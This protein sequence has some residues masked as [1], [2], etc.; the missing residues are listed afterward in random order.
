MAA[1]LLSWPLFLVFLM[2][3]KKMDQVGAIAGFMCLSTRNRHL[4]LAL[5]TYLHKD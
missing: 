4:P 5:A 3:Q 1:Y 2:L